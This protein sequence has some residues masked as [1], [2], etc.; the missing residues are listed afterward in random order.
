M[1]G[2]GAGACLHCGRGGCDGDGARRGVKATYRAVSCL[3]RA[4]LS[5]CRRRRRRWCR[6]RAC[7]GASTH[8]CVAAAT[9]REQRPWWRA[10]CTPAIRFSTEVSQCAAW[11]RWR[12]CLDPDPLLWRVFA[13]T[14]LPHL[15][16]TTAST[17]LLFL[18]TITT[19][20]VL[21]T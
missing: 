21:I 17:L 5:V 8:R 6:L 2:G 1:R 10:Q 18:L 15:T 19:A 4:A 16:P 14:R 9:A 3:A 7:G 13:C 12:L 11:R 20:Y